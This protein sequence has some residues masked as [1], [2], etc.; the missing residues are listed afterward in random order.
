MRRLTPV[1]VEAIPLFGPALFYLLYVGSYILWSDRVPTFIALLV[2]LLLAALALMP[3][4]SGLGW[5]VSGRPLVGAA[6]MLLRAV[7]AW[8][9]VTVLLKDDP[10]SIYA[11]IGILLSVPVVSIPA[12]WI[13]QRKAQLP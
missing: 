6:I 4:L 13:V 8:L 1:V 5:V 11:G 12:L 10:V 7:T 3:L 2:G 9:G